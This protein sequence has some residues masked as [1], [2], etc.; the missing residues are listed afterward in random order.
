MI[1]DMLR[2]NWSTLHSLAADARSMTVRTGSGT[3]VV[4]PHRAVWIPARIPHAITMSGLVS[5][6]TLYLKPRLAK[7]LPRD[8]CVINV[9]TLLKELILHV[10]VVRTLKTSVNSQKDLIAVIMAPA[11][12]AHARNASFGTRCKSNACSSGIWL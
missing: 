10:C 12:S 2:Q 7:G 11:T 9:S 8:C 6:R 5:M 1:D 3:W 4:P